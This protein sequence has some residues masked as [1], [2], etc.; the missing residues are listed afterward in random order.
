MRVCSVQPWL[1]PDPLLAL[2]MAH[3][4]VHIMGDTGLDLH[5]ACAT[6]RPVAAE[7]INEM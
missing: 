5:P 7:G 2:G 6:G 3:Q 4:E 1:R